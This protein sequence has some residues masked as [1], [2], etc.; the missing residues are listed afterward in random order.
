[1]EVRLRFTEACPYWL[2]AHER[3]REALRAEGLG[4]PEPI[5][6]RIETAGDSE[7]LEFVSSPTILLNGRDP[8][9]GRGTTFGLGCRVHQSPEGLDGLPSV[10]QL[11]DA[12]RREGLNRLDEHE[13]PLSGTSRR[14]F[15]A[16][17]RP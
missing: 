8:F 14:P 12:L 11:R 3:L 4:N 5:L 15:P 13:A 1:M 7:R 2:T 17:R 10:A 16:E 6:E 9:A